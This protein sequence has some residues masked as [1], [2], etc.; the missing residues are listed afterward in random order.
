LDSKD[1]GYTLVQKALDYSAFSLQPGEF[2]DFLFDFRC[3]SPGTY[4]VSFEV[5]Y[6]YKGETQAAS[7]DAPVHFVCP[8]SYAIWEVD[9][10]ITYRYPFELADSRYSSA[11]IPVQIGDTYIISQPDDQSVSCG[12]HA[13]NPMSIWESP[14]TSGTIIRNLTF[15]ETITIID[16]PV[17]ENGI[18]W[19][20]INDENNLEGWITEDLDRFKYVRRY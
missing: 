15:C 18:N 10:D 12:E 1:P 8:S 17:F 16:G 19:W 6:T 11:T 20:K 2:E 3:M 5:L 4:Q 9:S 13:E 14:L 7:V